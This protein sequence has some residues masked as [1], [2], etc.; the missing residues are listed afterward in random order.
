MITDTLHLGLVRLGA[1]IS[2]PQVRV[3]IDG[4]QELFMS[5]A[6]WSSLRGLGDLLHAADSELARTRELLDVYKTTAA[7]QG[8]LANTLIKQRDALKRRLHRYAPIR[9]VLRDWDWRAVAREADNLS[10][11]YWAADALAK[12]IEAE[13]A[14]KEKTDV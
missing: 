6:Q 1:Y 2:G 14:A 3:V 10:P 5:V 11:L 12:V 7:E 13:E 9:N 8:Q 4:E